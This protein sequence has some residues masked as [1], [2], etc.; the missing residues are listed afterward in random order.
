M[1]RPW[2]WRIAVLGNSGRTTL[3]EM[4]LLL[5]ADKRGIDPP[6]PAWLAEKRA[7]EA[8]AL[9]AKRSARAAVAQA[10][11][12]EWKA[13]VAALPVEIK[14]AHNYESHRHLEN[15]VQ[16]GDHILVTVDFAHGRLHRSA[17][18][19][20]CETPSYSHNLYFPHWDGPDER[21]PT[22]K[23]CIRAACRITG[24]DAPTLLGEVKR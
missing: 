2:D 13:L 21:W 8:V 14:V 6:L 23:K 12:T 18:S 24:L 1:R 4:H 19:S 7:S 16:G 3:L 11:E 17:G 22:C 9:E 20:F 15:Y 5:I 10:R